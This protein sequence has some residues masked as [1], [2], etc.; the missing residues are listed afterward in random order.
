MER[1][2]RRALTLL[3]IVAAV[4]IALFV[5]SVAYRPDD[6]GP[7]SGFPED[8]REAWRARLFPSQ[9]VAPGQLGGCT[10]A[11][12]PFTIAG[13]CELRIA[14]ADARSRRLILE[15]TDPVE[16]RRTVDA[17]GR[18]IA[19]RAELKAGKR[20]Q[21]FV[22][23]AGETLGLRCLAGIPCRAGVVSPADD[24]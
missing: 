21:I 14:A 2:D 5:I 3:A 18:R 8:R 23:K 12:G 19:M 22:G 17:D 13:S 10:A 4:L 7:G 9:P 20:E 6:R 15:A 11:V 1:A 24:R 16:L